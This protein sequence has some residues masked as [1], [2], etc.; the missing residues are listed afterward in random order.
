M[1]DTKFE[2][3]DR[4]TNKD[5]QDQVREVHDCLHKVGGR[6]EHQGL[7]I[8]MLARAM[9]LKLPT[10]DEMKDGAEPRPVRTRLGGL[11][12]FQAICYA[13][14]AMTGAQAL[15]KILEPTVVAA[16]IV[17]HHQLMR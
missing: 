17:L 6:V 2:T 13:V 12:P 16:A 10:E 3:R 15:Y 8:G 7:Q 14:G 1:A 11:Q 5:I 9:G 4:P